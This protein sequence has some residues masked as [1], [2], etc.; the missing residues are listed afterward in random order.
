M[1]FAP[2]EDFENVLEYAV[3]PTFDLVVELPEDGGVVLARRTIAPY[4]NKRAL[5]VRARSSRP[6]SRPRFH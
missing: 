4:R 2:R 6:R 5:P 1:K 3:I